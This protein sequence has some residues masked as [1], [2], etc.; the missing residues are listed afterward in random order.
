MR[1]TLAA[2]DRPA[3]ESGVARPC[4][5][6]LFLRVDHSAQQFADNRRL[7]ATCSET[8]Q[9]SEPPFVCLAL[10]G[11]DRRPYTV[12]LVWAKYLRL[13]F[14]YRLTHVAMSDAAAPVAA[15][16]SQHLAVLNR[17]RLRNSTK[18]VTM[19]QTV[20]SVNSVNRR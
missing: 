5:G 3:C 13:V 16:T 14:H 2:I 10:P 15:A 18:P 20:I 7:A 6:A 11:H 4:E 8:V 1:P 12:L 17:F 19:F 9:R